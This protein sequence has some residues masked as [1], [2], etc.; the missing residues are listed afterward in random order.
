MFII[1]QDRVT[2]IL[3]L[4]YAVG[5]TII[6]IGVLWQSRK[7]DFRAADALASSRSLN[8][9]HVEMID[10]MAN[11]I[12]HQKAQIEALRDPIIRT[13]ALLA[14]G[15]RAHGVAPRSR[16]V[17]KPEADLHIGGF[18][19]TQLDSRGFQPTSV[20]PAR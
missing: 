17:A 12:A 15:D 3:L 19:V 16:P 9:R 10:G 8:L 13:A 2:A 4:C 18:A 7:N 11:Q 14:E 20:M 5:V 1:P 6:L